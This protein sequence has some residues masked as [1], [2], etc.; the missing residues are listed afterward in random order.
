MSDW[1]YV[2]KKNRLG[3]QIGAEPFEP[4]YFYVWQCRHC[5]AREVTTSL[6]PARRR[7]KCTNGT[8]IE[9]EIE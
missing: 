4:K 5:G 9:K 2:E 1:S 3:V 6:E 8:E 7:C